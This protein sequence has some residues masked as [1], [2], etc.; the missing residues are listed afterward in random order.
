MGTGAQ[1]WSAISWSASERR[2]WRSATDRPR[3]WRWRGGAGVKLFDSGIDLIQDPEIDAVVVA[4]PVLTHFEL[5]AAALR[6]G[7]HVFVE[8][9]LAASGEQA[10]RLV[11]L[12]GKHRRVLMTGHVFVYAG[13][14]R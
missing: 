1:T 12:A 7:K 6:Q 4:T 8:K 11:D 10:R 3:G 2:L 14:V 5:A 13:A 9:P